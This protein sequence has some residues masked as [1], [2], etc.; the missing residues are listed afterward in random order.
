VRIYLVWLSFNSLRLLSPPAKSD[1]QKM[2]RCPEVETFG[3]FGAR[4][5]K[6]VWDEWD[7]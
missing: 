2:P 5:T 7:E 6:K 1:F 3:V 4:N